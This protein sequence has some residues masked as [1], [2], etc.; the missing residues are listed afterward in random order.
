MLNLLLE[1]KCENKQKLAEQLEKSI[2]NSIQ[3][4]DKVFYIL[5]IGNSLVKVGF[6]FNYHRG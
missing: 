5:D 3:E 1:N 2:L 6:T 4:N